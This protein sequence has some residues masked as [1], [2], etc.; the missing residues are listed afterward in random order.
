M[1]ATATIRIDSNLFS[2]TIVE[3]KYCTARLIASPSCN[4]RH[5]TGSD[6]TCAFIEY[7]VTLYV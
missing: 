2:R 6:L 4:Q 7:V 5:G 3:Q 1:R